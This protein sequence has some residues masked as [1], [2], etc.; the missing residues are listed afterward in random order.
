MR[1][2]S[3]CFRPAIR[4]DVCSFRRVPRIGVSLSGQQYASRRSAFR[5]SYR[6]AGGDVSSSYRQAGSIA[7]LASRRHLVRRAVSPIWGVM[8]DAEGTFSRVRVRV[9]VRASGGLYGLY[10]WH[11]GAFAVSGIAAFAL[12]V[13]DCHQF[14]AS[15][16]SAQHWTTAT[17]PHSTRERAPWT[18]DMG[19]VQR[20]A[21]REAGREMKRKLKLHISTMEKMCINSDVIDFLL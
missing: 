14:R 9:G 18:C 3:F 8:R 7:V 6:Q 20:D 11:R 5:Q 21:R 16:S 15:F 19:M 13:V 12:P 17:L 2:G 4:P 1:G 10:G